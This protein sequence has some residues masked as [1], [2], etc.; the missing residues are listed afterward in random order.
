MRNTKYKLIGFVVAGALL[1]IGGTIFVLGA[2]DTVVP[3]KGVVLRTYQNIERGIAFEYPAKYFLEAK[4]VG[5]GERWHFV[6][7]L[8]EDTEENRAV[9][10]GRAPGREGPVAISF[11]FYQNN[12]DTLSLESWLKSTNAS[13][14]KLSDGTYINTMVAGRDAVKYHWS[15]LYEADNVALATRDAILSIAVTY[16]DPAESIRQDFENILDT[17]RIAQ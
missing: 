17:L 5:N 3:D 10:E 9:R 6:I 7:T 15:G 14:F 11:D 12:L 8:T 16:I 13:N 2:F 1:I 4:E